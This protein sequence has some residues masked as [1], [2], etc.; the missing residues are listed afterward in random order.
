MSRSALLPFTVLLA[1][2]AL[3]LGGCAA[4]T[5]PAS[6]APA[7]DPHWSYEGASGPVGWGALDPGFADCA[8]GT[9]QSPIDLQT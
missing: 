4:T 5:E 8:T 3:L 2:G 6:Q 7:A 9:R 1:A